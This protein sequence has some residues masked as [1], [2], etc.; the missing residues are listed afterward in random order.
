MALSE[1]CWKN[2]HPFAPS[3]DR[4]L[5]DGDYTPD[6][7]RL[8]CVAVN[9][10]MGQWGQEVYMT[11]AQAAVAKEKKEQTDP[12]PTGDADWDARQDEKIAAVTALLERAS[13]AKKD[14][15]EGGDAR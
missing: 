11:P 12:D 2:K 14:A 5:S 15:L 7:V 1:P 13:E 10:G 8:V 4:I 6:N 9:F 3:I